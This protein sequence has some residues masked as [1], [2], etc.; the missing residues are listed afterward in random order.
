VPSSDAYMSLIASLRLHCSLAGLTLAAFRET[1]ECENGG[2]YE[3]YKVRRPLMRGDRVIVAA[4]IT[5]ADIRPHPEGAWVEPR[6][7]E[8]GDRYI[9]R[10]LQDVM[11][12]L[13]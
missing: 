10:A 13:P 6:R 11:R 9:A 2:E 5:V 7:P 1:E 12:V 4:F 8:D 3:Y